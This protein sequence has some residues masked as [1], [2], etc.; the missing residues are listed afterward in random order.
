LEGEQE[1]G[2]KDERKEGRRRRSS[3]TGAKTKLAMILSVAKEANVS[4]G[5]NKACSDRRSGKDEYS[6]IEGSRTGYG[7]S[8]KKGPL[9]DGSR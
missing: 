2:G 8:L 9:C 7:S 4:T 3:K 6:S 5:N 1:R